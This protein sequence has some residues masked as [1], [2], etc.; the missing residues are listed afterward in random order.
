M[1]KVSFLVIA[2]SMLLSCTGYQKR[3]EFPRDSF[4]HV[5]QFVTI[6]KCAKDNPFDCRD[7]TSGISGSGSI[8]KVIG[9]G[10]YVLTAAHVCESEKLAKIA[11]TG[12]LLETK[13]H[14]VDI[15]GKAYPLVVLSANTSADLCL[16]FAE[17][18]LGGTALKLASVAPRPGERAYNMAAPQGIFTINMFPLFDGYYAGH[19]RSFDLY[20]IPATQGS[21]GSP[22]LNSDGHLIGIIAMSFTGFQ[23]MSL[24]PPYSQVRAFLSTYL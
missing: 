18:L 5:K 15:N 12:K 2:L 21:S 24:S 19:D 13:F 11:K 9:N 3:F 7:F 1:S 6:K 20:T 23:S 4:I 16:L 10:S 14:A 17:G 8:V 22:I